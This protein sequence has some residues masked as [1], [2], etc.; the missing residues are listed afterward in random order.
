MVTLRKIF[1]KWRNRR[2]LDNNVQLQILRR[3]ARLLKNG[4][5]LIEALETMT[6]ENQLVAPIKIIIRSLK[7]GSTIDEA[8]ETAKFHPVIISHLYFVRLN[9]DLQK[10]IDNCIEIFATRMQQMK[11]FRQI[12]HYPLFLLI[13]FCILLL[14]I[15]NSI[16][17]SFI[18]LV[19]SSSDAS[20]SVIL[21]IQLINLLGTTMI[22]L[23]ILTVITSVIWYFAKNKLLIENQ[24]KIYNM[25][26]IY[27][28]MI[29]LQTSYHFATHMSILFRT[30]L[31]IK[32]VLNQMK[33]QKK[34]P[35]V[36]HY[37][38][39][40]KNYLSKGFHVSD[41][42]TQLSMLDHQLATILQNNSN[43][44]TLQR[45]LDTYSE[46]LLEQLK[47]KMIKIITL[48][49]PLFFI[50]IAVFIVFIYAILMWPMFQL[51]NTI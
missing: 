10:S 13:I 32:E 29:R 19:Q 15:K 51:I 6:W 49:Q 38:F 14:F 4:Y 17:P 12:M 9:G 44:E 45:D 41:F 40:I 36:A 31:T 16:L 34:L 1:F 18:D 21:S 37:S 50:V 27:R 8:F 42:L 25:I 5:T 28:T 30:G 46:L 47:E 35:I 11:K 3:L 23:T 7:E 24:I 2:K 20:R 48:I 33:L 39:L 22:I 43:I 26:P